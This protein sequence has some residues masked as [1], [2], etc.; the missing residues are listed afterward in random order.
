VERRR[1]GADGPEISVVGVGTAP[2]GSTR[3]WVYWGPQDEA[4]ALAAIRAALDA[5][6]NW[7]DTAPFYGWGRAEE[8]VRRALAGRDD[9]L[10][11]TKCGTLPAEDAVSRMD[12]R[13]E[14]IRADVE[15][16]L[17]RLGRETVDLVHI[18]D[19]DHETP[20]EESWGELQ[21]LRGEGKIRW[22][23]LSNHT[24]ELVERAHAVA[25]VTSCQDQLSLLAG[26]DDPAVLD[27]VRRL[28]IGLL[29]WA[30]LA[31]GFLTDGFDLETLDPDDFRRRSRLAARGEE[32]ETLRT[33]AAARGRTL[34]RHAVAW[35]LEQPGVTA[36]IVGPRTAA[37]GAELALLASD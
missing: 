6:A 35:V 16:S 13:P 10:V 28:G 31:S 14:S 3:E 29:C 30:P 26:P 25:P 15:A 33:E 37:E 21:R 7:I 4:E 20:I 2:I 17:R 27:V 8:L 34:R 18:H 22:A 1:L 12:N 32:I 5:G 36:A 24:A 19:I 23:G 9:V 11:F